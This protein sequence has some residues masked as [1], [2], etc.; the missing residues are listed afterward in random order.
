MLRNRVHSPELRQHIFSAWSCLLAKTQN[1][2]RR[3]IRQVREVTQMD[4]T[5]SR[6]L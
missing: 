6:L 2:L 1:N 5:R 4:G 3:F